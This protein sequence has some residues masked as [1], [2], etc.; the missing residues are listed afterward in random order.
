MS[1]TLLLADDSITIQRVIEL[2]FADEQIRV[3]VAGDGEQAIAKIAAERPDVVLADVGM[4]RKDG[5]AVA[6]HIK[7]SPDLRHIPVLLLTGAFEPID[8]A[9]ARETG[10]DGVLVKPFEPQ[11]LVARV[12]ELLDGRRS[13]ALWPADM[14]RVEPPPAH[15]AARPF[16]RPS[17]PREVETAS[18]L[19]ASVPPVVD[20][21]PLSVT[22]PTR[23]RDEAPAPFR[24]SVERAGVGDDVNRRPD[25][26]P[27]GDNL[28]S[29]LDLLDAA[30]SQLDPTARPS[31]LDAATASE[32]ARDLREMRQDVPPAQADDDFSWERPASKP[33]QPESVR[34]TPVPEPMSAP[35]KK[36]D[37]AA[38]GDWDLPAPASRG[39]DTESP[40]D[41]VVEE[42]A[43]S[44]AASAT[45]AWPSASH[46]AASPRPSSYRSPEPPPAPVQ[47]PPAQPAAVQAPPTASAPPA[48]SAGDRPALSSAFAALLAAERTQP[49]ADPAPNVPLSESAIDEIVK[50]VLARMTG[51]TVHRVV[52]E[53][54]ERMIREEIA[55]TK[56][57]TDR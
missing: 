11:V 10:C 47:P 16:D 38:F 44:P 36:P 39:G 26:P 33:P 37:V 2:T 54:A 14:P 24:E 15:Q 49:K 48:P 53:T 18:P 45:Q 6:A 5:Y 46:D 23:D 34:P 28:D 41:V 27:P 42:V 1:A 31:E 19:A 17:S 30:L 20:A 57:P 22:E 3:V 12:R 55:R 29:E 32:F 56:G 25:L 9:R 8:E 40:I 51:D 52:L 35:G 13:Q 43:P 7:Q 21:A 50:R 4:P